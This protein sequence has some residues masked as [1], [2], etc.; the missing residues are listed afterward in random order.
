[1]VRAV[2]GALKQ[3]ARYQSVSTGLLRSARGLWL[4]LALVALFVGLFVVV[5]ALNLPAFRELA[6]LG[7]PFLALSLIS[8]RLAR[9][10]GG[11]SEESPPE[12]APAA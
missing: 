4:G 8:A 10:V 3:S 11:S 9:N 6:L 2:V 12:R 7:V 1:M 5:W